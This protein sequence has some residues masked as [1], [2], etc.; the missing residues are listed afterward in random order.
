MWK[1][2]LSLDWGVP[3]LRCLFT[4]LFTHCHPQLIPPGGWAACPLQ[5]PG[6]ILGPYGCLIEHTAL[7]IELTALSPRPFPLAAR[8]GTIPQP[9]GTPVPSHRGQRGVEESKGSEGGVVETVQKTCPFL[10]ANQGW[11]CE[12][13]ATKGPSLHRAGEPA[14]YMVLSSSRAAAVQNKLTEQERR[15]FSI[16]THKPFQC[17]YY[18][19][20]YFNKCDQYQLLKADT[21]RNIFYN[22]TVNCQVKTVPIFNII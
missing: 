8:R 19:S 10:L 4:P 6:P 1:G 16:N 22:E 3:H 15:V 11:K 5:G 12:L 17:L 9:H 7:L 13:G 18:A 21:R 14:S 20:K 2:L